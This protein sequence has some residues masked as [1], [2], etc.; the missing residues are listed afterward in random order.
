MSIRQLT[1]KQERF[2]Q[3]YVKNGGNG[4]LAYMSAY[5]SNSPTSAKP[6]AYK[7][8][9]RDDITDY[10]SA[11]TKPSENQAKNERAKKRAILWQW[12]TDPNTKEETKARA[13]DI[14]NKMDNEYKTVIENNENLS[15]EGLSASDLKKI[16]SEQ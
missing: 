5:N 13:M 16:L 6:E 8:L 1:I 9:Q 4:T 2:C 7:L 14:L 10:I 12:I 11:L 3:E 15:L